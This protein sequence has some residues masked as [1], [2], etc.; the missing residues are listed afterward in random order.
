MVFKRLF[1]DPS[2]KNA[3]SIYKCKVLTAELLTFLKAE[4]GNVPLLSNGDVIFGCI[5]NFVVFD[6]LKCFEVSYPLV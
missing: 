2:R 5:L 1:L 3:K 4:G 6:Q